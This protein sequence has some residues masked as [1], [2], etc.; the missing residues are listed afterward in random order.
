MENRAGVLALPLTL[1]PRW[2]EE[3]NTEFEA[4]LDNTVGPCQRKKGKKR[5]KKGRRRGRGEGGK[6]E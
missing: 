4:R 1:A 6:A 3:K 5:K 2:L